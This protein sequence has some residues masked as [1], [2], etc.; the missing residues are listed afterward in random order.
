MDSRPIRNP[1]IIEALEA[2][3]P[4]SDDLSQPPMAP[5]ARQMALLPE[6][7]DLRERLQ[8]TDQAIGEA[9]QRV[10]VPPGLAAQ[11]LSR[12]AP[13]A[14]QSLEDTPLP[15]APVVGA[16]GRAAGGWRAQ[17]GA[18]GRRRWLVAFGG[19]LAAAAC[20]LVALLLRSPPAANITLEQLL[21]EAIAFSQAEGHALGTPFALGAPA[22][23][24]FPLPKALPVGDCAIW[25]R[26][27]RGLLN[28]DGVAYQIVSPGGVRA[29]LY[30]IRQNPPGVGAVPPDRPMLATGMRAAAV[31]QEGD[32][33]YVLVVEGESRDYERLFQ[34][35]AS[36]PIT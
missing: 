18:T 17:P 2:C 34:P 12:L 23:G 15:E 19:L 32:L 29:T 30:V 11:I 10:E 31:W 14:E 24:G 25:W 4:G 13:K 20:L 21:Q 3:R 33:L 22:P 1:R 26:Y 28:S 6:L 36:G 35:G 8:Q 16:P 27:V 5:L 7:A 9:F